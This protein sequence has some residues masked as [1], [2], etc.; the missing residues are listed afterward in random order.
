VRA[1][2]YSAEEMRRPRK[3]KNFNLKNMQFFLDT[4]NL[5]DIKKYASWGIVD[6]V[7]TNPSLVAKEGVNLKDRILEI[8]EIVDGPLSAEVVSEDHEGMMEEAHE[9]AKWHKNIYIKVPMTSEG[10]KTVKALTAE[11]IKTNVTL[12]FSLGQAIMAAKAGA[13]LLS[14]FVGRLDDI[15]D[16]GI[17]LIGEIVQTFDNYGFETKVL[18]ASIRHPRHVTEAAMLGADICT[19]PPAIF[20]KLVSHPLTDKGIAAFLADWDKVKDKQ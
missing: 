14:P 17:G 16:D 11:G 19:M 4:A 8:S 18:V 2:K 9:F 12:V 13:T 6:G 15:C 3:T 20:D 1:I 10:L 5:E 7:T